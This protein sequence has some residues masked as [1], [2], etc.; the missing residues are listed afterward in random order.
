MP[1]NSM[2][3]GMENSYKLFVLTQLIETACEF[4]SRPEMETM[5]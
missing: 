1:A 2:L 4:L 5:G 3:A